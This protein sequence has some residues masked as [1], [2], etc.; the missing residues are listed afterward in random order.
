MKLL[1][2]TLILPFRRAGTPPG[3]AAS[4]AR[5]SRSAPIL[6]AS[7]YIALAEFS[8][9]H[10]VEIGK[11]VMVPTGRVAISRAAAG[12]EHH[13]AFPC[14]ST[15]SSGSTTSEAQPLAPASGFT[16]HEFMA[17]KFELTRKLVGAYGTNQHVCFLTLTGLAA[18]S[19]SQSIMRLDMLI[20]DSVA[21]VA[22]WRTTRL[23]VFSSS[24]QSTAA[25][26]NFVNA[27]ASS[28]RPLAKSL[29]CAARIVGCALLVL[30]ALRQVRW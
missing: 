22:K 18:L 12:F 9:A 25:R 7:I 19:R 11:G 15:T 23:L 24:R 14:R 17:P 6:G 4:S 2:S 29:S 13:V 26:P 20:R 3:E 1:H 16:C 27:H 5:L 8:A 10:T 21:L 30:R 28:F